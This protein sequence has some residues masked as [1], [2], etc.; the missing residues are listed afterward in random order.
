MARS[1]TDDFD[2]AEVRADLRAVMF[3]GLPDDPADRPIFHFPDVPA[4]A[5]RDRA[6]QPWDFSEAALP[7]ATAPK[8]DVLCGPDSGEVVC[9]YTVLGRQ[10]RAPSQSPF[11]ALDAERLEFT[12]LDVD[13]ELIKGF[14]SVT[15]GFTTY[16]Y[17]KTLPPDGLSDL[18]VFTVVVAADDVL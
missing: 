6:G 17:D 1:P 5:K 9:T 14:T 4:Y 10:T 16:R 2:T 8:P 13:Y 3:M 11:G 7:P 12:F 18:G 15:I